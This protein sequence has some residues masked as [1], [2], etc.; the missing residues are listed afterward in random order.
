M[1]P[2][3]SSDYV[4]GRICGSD[5]AYIYQIYSAY[6]I[7]QK[8]PGPSKLYLDVPERKLVSMGYFFHLLIFM[9]GIHWGRN[10]PL[11]RSPLI[12][13]LPGQKGHPS[14]DRALGP[15]HPTGHPPRPSGGRSQNLK[16]R[17]QNPV[18][19]L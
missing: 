2:V 9:G 15:F 16:R 7:A 14:V 1:L 6:I 10:K 13:P 4:S 11:M 3:D 19:G 18:A 5:S 8:K 17:D 12:Y